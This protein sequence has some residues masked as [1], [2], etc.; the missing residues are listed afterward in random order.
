MAKPFWTGGF[1]RES[2]SVGRFRAEL[3]AEFVIW[4]P[5]MARKISLA[6]V[7][8]GTAD[9]LDLLK[10]NAIMD[11]QDEADRRASEKL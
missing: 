6:E 7:K 2:Q 1:S 11:M 5:V 9:L 4:R 3:E 10:I 8:D